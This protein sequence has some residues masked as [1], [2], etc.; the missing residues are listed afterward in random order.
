MTETLPI[1]SN[2]CIPVTELRFVYARS[3]GP[4]GQN[5]NKVN[6]KVTL[7]FDV[8]ASATL[9][10]VQKSRLY[11]RLASRIDRR[12]VLHIAVDEHRT[13]AAN[14]RA[15]LERFADLLRWAL[16][17]RKLRLPTKP[18]AASQRRRLDSKTR[19]ST[20]KRLRREPPGQE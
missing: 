13:Q 4:G 2:L 7:L 15:A 18:T 3:S 5:V 9:T 1:T 16:A 12:G 8:S 20:T 6:T 17:R 11:R 19:R 10:D 14:R